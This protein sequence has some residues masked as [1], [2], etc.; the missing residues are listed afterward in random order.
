[1]CIEATISLMNLQ[2]SATAWQ[3]IMGEGLPELVVTEI[4]PITTSFVA[5]MWDIVTFACMLTSCI[6]AL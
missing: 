3:L 2:L 6:E 5:M 4:I 1:M